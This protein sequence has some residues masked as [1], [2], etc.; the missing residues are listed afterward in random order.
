MS[1]V[2]WAPTQRNQTTTT[3]TSKTAKR[4]TTTTKDTNVVSTAKISKKI[5]SSTVT[6][7]TI[8]EKPGYTVTPQTTAKKSGATARLKEQQDKEINRSRSDSQRDYLQVQATAATF[9]NA[10]VAFS[11]SQE[12]SM[13]FE[14]Y[15]E[16][17][18]AYLVGVVTRY[19]INNEKSDGGVCVPR[20]SFEIHGVNTAFQTETHVHR[21]VESAVDAGWG[22]WYKCKR[23]VLSL[24]SPGVL[25]V[26]WC[27]GTLTFHHWQTPLKRL[28]RQDTANGQPSEAAKSNT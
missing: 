9:L 5:F 4:L 24:A 7:K 20:P 13:A 23:T 2:A 17:G 27:Q 21:I 3:T 6:P 14:H 22:S 11:P 26:Q 16:V 18:G 19:S 10:R 15:S 1:S 8:A 25:C 28:T 12:D